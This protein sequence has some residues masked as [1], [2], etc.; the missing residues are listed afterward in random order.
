MKEVQSE[1]VIKREGQSE[2]EMR[3]RERERKS[4]REKSKRETGLHKMGPGMIFKKKIFFSY[5]PAKRF[6]PKNRQ[7][8]ELKSFYR[9]P[10]FNL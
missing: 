10:K 8:I 9:L 7:P 6:F 1:I 5:N 4:E 3:E 2:R